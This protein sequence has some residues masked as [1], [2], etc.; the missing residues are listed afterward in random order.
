MNMMDNLDI[1]LA[2]FKR[3]KSLDRDILVYNNLVHIRKKI[4]DYKLHKKIQY[5]WL[6][7]LTVAL[8]FKKFAGL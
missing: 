6:S 5:V 3:M 1:G 7:V 4:G 8:G 2:E